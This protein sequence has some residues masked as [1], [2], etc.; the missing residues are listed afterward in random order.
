MIDK[1]ILGKDNK[2]YICPVDITMSYI[3]KKWCIQIIKDLLI[4]R[5]RFKDFL[6]SNDTLSSKVLSDRLKELCNNGIIEKKIFNTE[7]ILI[8]YYITARGRKLNN[9][10]LEIIK[11]TENEFPEEIDYES[12]EFQRIVTILESNKKYCVKTKVDN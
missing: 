3:G 11:F 4:G 6:E 9:V 1:K 7:P 12:C 8:E 10:L 5:K 2:V